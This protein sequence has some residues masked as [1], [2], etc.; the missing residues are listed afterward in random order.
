MRPPLLLLA[1]LALLASTAAPALA[2][3]GE[4]Q[5]PSIELRGP[6]TPASAD[7]VG[8]ALEAA[9]GDGARFAIIRLDTPGGLDSAVE[10][11]V[12]RVR[13]A[14]PNIAPRLNRVPAARPRA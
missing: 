2:Q 11:I 1:A 12:D 3:S 6:L 13:R 5:I 8:H 4:E 10:E 9:E 14:P 7:W